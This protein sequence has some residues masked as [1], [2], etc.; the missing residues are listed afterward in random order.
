MS[1][2]QQKADDRFDDFWPR[3]RAALRSELG[4]HRYH[5]WIE[6]VRLVA[7]DADRIVL[8]GTTRFLKDHVSERFGERITQLSAHFSGINRPVEFVVEAR[9]KLE[10][11]VFVA[12]A[13]IAAPT[14]A[15]GSI[16][17]DPRLTFANFVT[18]PSNIVAFT[19][20]QRIAQAAAPTPVPI[21]FYGGTGLGKSHLA[22]ACAHAALERNPGLRVLYV[23]AEL[24]VREFVSACL[25][26]KTSAFKDA[27]RNVDMLILDDAQFFAG[28]EAT[29]EEFF[30][31][32][33]SLVA[34]KK[35]A[36]ITADRSPS[37]LDHLPERVRSR[38]VN[39]GG[40]EI[41]PTDFDLRL[42]ILT[43]K[44]EGL[45]R[46]RRGVAI[47]TD[48]LHMIAARITNNTRELEGALQR[49]AMKSAGH[50]GPVT[51]AAAEEW[52]SDFL[53]AHRKI[54]IEDV[55]R[56]VMERYALKAG[57]L[58][59]RSRKQEIVRPRQVAMFLARR[60]T[61]RSFPEIARKF[62]PRD[63]TTVIHGCDRIGELM[64][65]NPEIAAEV[66]DLQR[67]LRN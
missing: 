36:I 60:L 49:I 25:G 9:P 29:I 54:T 32:V 13:P 63:H 2:Q 1:L 57:E 56:R 22:V 48:V 10:V 7:A 64:I 33:D 62:G 35:Q 19:E 44:V 46:E 41:G 31:T 28:K 34:N 16:P 43:A 5:M 8:D 27:V 30:H 50:A 37:L 40:V 14:L 45:A 11:P 58:E 21:V 39:G 55:K 67:L 3:V 52:L 18:G 12:E 24:F 4:D 61:G 20:A 47:G 6:P 59:S 38:L 17:L 23:T 15:P 42:K 51:M 26:N 65:S 66:E 53:R